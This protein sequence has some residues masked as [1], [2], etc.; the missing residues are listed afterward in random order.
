MDTS[1]SEAE[2]ASGQLSLSLVS[3]GSDIEDVDASVAAIDNQ[4]SDTLVPPCVGDTTQGTS[5]ISSTSISEEEELIAEVASQLG[6][7]GVSYDKL[8]QLSMALEKMRAS[9]RKYIRRKTIWDAIVTVAKTSNRLPAQTAQKV[10]TALDHIGLLDFVTS[11]DID[12]NNGI[13]GLSERDLKE[14]LPIDLTALDIKCL[15]EA[16]EEEISLGHQRM[17]SLSGRYTDILSKVSGPV[18]SHTCNSAEQKNTH[19]LLSLCQDLNHEICVNEKSLEELDDVSSTLAKVKIE[20]FNHINS[21]RLNAFESKCKILKTHVKSLNDQIVN[22]IYLEDKHLI[23]AFT[24]LKK[25]VDLLVTEAKSELSV[26]Q[27]KN[28][29][30]EKL[31]GT[32]FDHIVSEYLDLKRKIAEKE[33]SLKTMNKR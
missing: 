29:G 24:E 16:V 7:S 9:Q 4:C 10:T 13:F 14:S 32:H 28:S 25:N 11:T 12:S 5:S 15:R 17:L 2:E 19:E 1:C 18:V 31:R 6:L 3:Y 8:D 27:Q 33:F 20:N 21:L 22:G 26:L 23:D 30:F